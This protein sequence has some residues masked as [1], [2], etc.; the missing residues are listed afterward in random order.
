MQEA[1]IAKVVPHRLMLLITVVLLQILPIAHLSLRPMDEVLV[2]ILK[3][4]IS[5][6]LQ[7]HMIME[8]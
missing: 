4:V 7:A 1:F 6:Y 8:L 3:A 5:P 2:P